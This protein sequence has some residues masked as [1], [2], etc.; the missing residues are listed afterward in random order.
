MGKFMDVGNFHHRG[1]TEECWFVSSLVLNLFSL[2][3]E[4]T[5]CRRHHHC[6]PI[7]TNLEVPISFFLCHK[8]CWTVW[9]TPLLETCSCCGSFS[10]ATI[11]IPKIH[12]PEEASSIQKAVDLLPLWTSHLILQEMTECT[13]PA[14]PLSFL[15][16]YMYM[17]MHIHV[18]FRKKEPR[19]KVS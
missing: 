11:G 16:C 10:T 15:Q 12:V 1:L 8:P 3:S 14:F 6:P 18:L 2:G 7:W 9:T 13:L 4:T 17:F 19:G 5:N